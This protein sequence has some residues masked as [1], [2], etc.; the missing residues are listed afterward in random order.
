M[1]PDQLLS[2]RSPRD[3]KSGKLRRLAAHLPDPDCS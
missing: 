1:N 3:G 2:R